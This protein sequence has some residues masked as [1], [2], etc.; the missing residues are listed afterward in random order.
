[1]IEMVDNWTPEDYINNIYD[2]NREAAKNDPFANAVRL[3][4]PFVKVGGGDFIFTDSNSNPLSKI[5]GV[6]KSK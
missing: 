4:E 3:V 6:E 1:M 5:F 2:G